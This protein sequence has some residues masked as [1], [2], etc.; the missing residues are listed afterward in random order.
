VTAGDKWE[1]FA[2]LPNIMLPDLT[3]SNTVLNVEVGDIA[4]VRSTDERVVEA[5]RR[6]PP[7]EHLMSGFRTLTD[8]AYE[9]TVMIYR[10]DAPA[11]VKGPAFIDFRNAVAL[12]VVLRSWSTESAN[13]A[14]LYSDTFDIFPAYPTDSG[15]LLIIT[16]ATRS[17]YALGVK[18][19]ATPS[20][21]GRLTPRYLAQDDYLA[22][23]LAVFWCRCYQD[24]RTDRF[25]RSLFRS[26]E[27]AYAAASA[28][29]RH[30]ATEN[31]WGINIALWVSAIEVL[32]HPRAHRRTGNV[33]QKEALQF[34]G[35][36]QWECK[37][38]DA[39][40]R[41]IWLRGKGNGKPSL[42]VNAIQSA[43]HYLYKARSAYLHGN[44]VR[45]RTMFPF[46]RAPKT[47]LV[48]L[49]PLIYRTALC[50]YL[51]KRVRPYPGM[52][53]VNM[54]RGSAARRQL[55]IAVGERMRVNEALRRMLFPSKLE[56]A[57]D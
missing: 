47:S 6:S 20:P 27:I 18:F 9:P 50:A 37:K 5:R 32:A 24:G 33:D 7:V 45:K 41:T 39:A 3:T 49:A 54:D 57:S 10:A 17:L 51:Q 8:E 26:L 48:M 52:S 23:A 43:Y 2:A 31:E 11:T 4:M 1:V 29:M 56:L 44:K 42:R 16:P 46:K 22:R 40:R 14:L 38:L 25:S 13:D 12:S 30:N 53:R 28:P 36:Y 34:L 15:R 19:L 21:I 55:L 35:T